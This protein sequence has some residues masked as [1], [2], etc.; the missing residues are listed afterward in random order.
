MTNLDYTYCV[1]KD[2]PNKSKCY[3]YFGNH[4]FPSDSFIWQSDFYKEKV[5]CEYYVEK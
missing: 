2:C 5:D 4:E 1:S 3:R